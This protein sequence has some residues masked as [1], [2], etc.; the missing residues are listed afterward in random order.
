MSGCNGT[1]SAENECS[2]SS[3]EIPAPLTGHFWAL[4][5]SRSRSLPFS[6]RFRD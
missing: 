4:Q 6:L 3:S 5:G 1:K 2:E